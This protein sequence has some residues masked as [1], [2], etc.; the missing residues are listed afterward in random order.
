MIFLNKKLHNCK[1]YARKA[2][3]YLKMEIFQRKSKYDYNLGG[4]FVVI[5]D[6]DEFSLFSISQS[7]FLIR[8]R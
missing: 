3:S 8:K 7:I 6:G 4:V 1:L 2:Q 5:F